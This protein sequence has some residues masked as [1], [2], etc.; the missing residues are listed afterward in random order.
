[1][2]VTAESF[3]L[4]HPEF[5]NAD[6]DLVE[7][8]IADAEDLCPSAVWGDFADSGVRFRTARALA[9]LPAS[10]DLRLVN[11]DGSTVYD[12]DLARL[13]LTVASGGRVV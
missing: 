8:K 9:L 12:A 4:A 1:M 2:A 10:R 11:K 3:K 5:A 7:L 13:V 6:D